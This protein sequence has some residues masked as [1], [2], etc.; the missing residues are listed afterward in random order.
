MTIYDEFDR[1]RIAMEDATGVAM[2]TEHPNRTATQYWMRTIIAH[3]LSVKG[4][5][6][7]RIAGIFGR[8]RTT[9]YTARQRLRQAMELPRVYCD[10]MENMDAFKRRYFELYGEQL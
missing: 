5:K 6:D 2:E 7:G 3:F 8:D 9:I 4:W 10:V 1:M